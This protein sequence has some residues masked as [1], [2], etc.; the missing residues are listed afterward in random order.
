MGLFVDINKA[1]DSV[2]HTKLFELLGGIGIEGTDL[3]WFKSYLCNRKQFVYVNGTKSKYQSIK[4]GVPQGSVLG[5]LLFIIYINSVGDIGLKG[6][7]ILY[8]DDTNLFYTGHCHQYILSDMVGDIE[9]LNSWFNSI[10][11]KLNV[12]KTVCMCFKKNS[13]SLPN[14]NLVYEDSIIERVDKIKFLGIV[15]DENLNWVEH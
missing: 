2:N 4:T 12:K 14:P 13:S 9:C 1:F 8:A 3:E 7:P 6:N 15:L 11:L 5:P 10:S